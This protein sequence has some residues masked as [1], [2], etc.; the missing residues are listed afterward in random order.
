MTWPNVV[1]C[2]VAG[3]TVFGCLAIE[4]I[5]TIVLVVAAVWYLN[6]ENE[7]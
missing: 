1:A 6:R 2:L 5:G 3:A 4:P 7:G